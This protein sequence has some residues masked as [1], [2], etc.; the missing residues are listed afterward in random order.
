MT[1][2][3]A[4]VALVV[5]LYN[6]EALT[7]ILVREIETFRRDRPEIQEILLI[8]DGSRDDTFRNLVALTDGLDGYVLVRFSRNFGHQLAVTAGLDLVTANAAVIMDADLQDPLEVAGRMIDTWREGYD[9]VYGIRRERGG[10]SFTERWTARDEPREGRPG[11]GGARQ[12]W[13]AWG[14]LY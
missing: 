4:S 3:K 14:R 1:P 12:E 6:E 11:I 10:M 2:D 5:P 13:V 8:D 7:H 9:V